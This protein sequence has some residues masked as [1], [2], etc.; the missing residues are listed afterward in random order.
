MEFK[1]KSKIFNCFEEIISK[2]GHTHAFLQPFI[3][4]FPKQTQLIRCYALMIG[5]MI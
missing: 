2:S 5:M 4:P 3:T 1:L